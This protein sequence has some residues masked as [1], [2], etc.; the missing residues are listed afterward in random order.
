MRGGVWGWRFSPGS[1]WP[2]VPTEPQSLLSPRHNGASVRWLQVTSVLARNR[3]LLSWDWAL[4]SLHKGLGFPWFPC[5][6]LSGCA[7]TVVLR[8][9][10]AS[11]ALG[12]CPFPADGGQFPSASGMGLPGKCLA[13]ALVPSSDKPHT[14]SGASSQEFLVPFCREYLAMAC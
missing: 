6:W 3:K 12:C 11:Q 14:V 2:I 8:H 1:C 13:S 4:L 10:P 5:S 9:S 7:V